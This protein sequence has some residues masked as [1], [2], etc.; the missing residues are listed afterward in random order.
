MI[1]DSLPA[2]DTTAN[3]LQACTKQTS[4]PKSTYLPEICAG[5]FCRASKAA[6]DTEGSCPWAA[7]VDG[8]AGEAHPAPRRVDR[9]RGAV[10]GETRRDA[11]GALPRD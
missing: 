7:D 1:P 3:T 10:H 4:S 11:P 6:K 5:R 2:R 8:A 9:A